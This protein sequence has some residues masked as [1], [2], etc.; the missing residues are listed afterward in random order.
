LAGPSG[1]SGTAEIPS[2]S[3]AELQPITA[4]ALVAAMEKFAAAIVAGDV[5]RYGQIALELRPPVNRRRLSE[6]LQ[7]TGRLKRGPE[8]LARLPD[9]DEHR[10]A[11]NRW[12]DHLASLLPA[13]GPVVRPTTRPG[14]NGFR[15]VRRRPSDEPNRPAAAAATSASVRAVRRRLLLELDHASPAMAASASTGG[16][17]PG[18]DAAD[19]GQTS[20]NLRLVQEVLPGHVWP[21]RSATID[22]D[23]VAAPALTPYPDAAGRES[24]ATARGPLEGQRHPAPAVPNAAAPAA[25]LADDPDSGGSHMPW[26]KVMLSEPDTPTLADAL[27]ATPPG[28][29]THP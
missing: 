10:V 7:T 27:A 28:C 11:L 8:S 18:G 14:G 5:P 23:G 9:Y 19:A 16:A 22:A 13:Q 6:W 15:Q 17:H 2:A 24:A 26:W 12:E 1:R 20:V 21:A 29:A 25:T 3:T 4:A